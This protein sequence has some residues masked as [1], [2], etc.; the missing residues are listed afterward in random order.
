MKWLQE[1]FSFT[2]TEYRGAI[3]LFG[4]CL[5]IVGYQL[6][7]N[8]FINH[9][10]YSFDEEQ[11][12]MDSIATRIK[13]QKE[14]DDEKKEW[15]DY[16][17]TKINY[18][19]KSVDKPVNQPLKLQQF[20]PNTVSETTLKKMGLS[21]SVVKGMVNYRNS[22]GRFYKPADLL[23]IYTIDSALYVQLEGYI[24]IPSKI[25]KT[26]RERKKV[27]LNSADTALLKTLTGVGSY[28]ASKIIEYRNQLGGFTDVNQLFE[29]W[30]MDTA[31]LVKNEGRI[32]V[33]VGAINKLN[34]NRAKQEDLS[35]HPYISYKV[36]KII[37]NYR[38]QHGDFQSVEGLLKTGVVNKQLLEKISPYLAIE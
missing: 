17:K 37:V 16:S 1:Y 8:E 29:I 3:L 23:K 34:I 30:K 24:L 31:L 25:D 4:I 5:T 28:Y 15:K 10:T 38:N 13:Q 32:M 9:A 19:E 22:G 14:V 12:I 2:A 20:N 35:K 36:A 11:R 21:K 27:E 18:S 26:I 33:D 6:Y 7:Q